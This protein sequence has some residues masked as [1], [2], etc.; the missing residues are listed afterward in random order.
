MKKTF[1]FLFC[2]IGSIFFRSVEA[3]AQLLPPNQPE[4]DAC[5]ALALCGNIFTS[6]YSYQGV[7]TVS[8]L[9]NT[10]CS[11]GEGNSMWLV[12]NVTSPGSIVF[13]LAPSSPEDDYDFAVLDITNTNCGNLSSANVIRCN[14]NNN[15]PGSNVNG[16]IGLNSTSTVTNVTAGATGNSFCQQID[17][18]AGGV[19][20]I[21]INNFGNYQ[22]GGESSGFTIDFT[23]STAT[24]NS[25]GPPAIDSIVTSCDYSQGITLQLTQPIN[26]NSI[27][28]DASDFYLT[29]SGTV[30]S[31]VGNNCNSSGQGY[32]DIINITFSPSLAPGTYTLHPQIGTDGNTLLDLC[33]EPLFEADVISFTIP[34]LPAFESVSLAC[35]TITVQMTTPVDCN[36][37]AA[38]GSN[39]LING[40]ATLN[41]A[42]AAAINCNANNLSNTIVLTLA[43]PI[44]TVGTYTI[45]A[46]AGSGGGMIMDSCGNEQALGDN[47]T[48]TAPSLSPVLSLP[49][50]LTTCVNSGV[51]LPLEIVN[52]VPG[53][54][55]SFN[56]IP[57]NGLSSATAQQPVA[58]PA[59]DQLYTV[60][61]T[62]D[63]PTYCPAFDTVYV[64]VLSGFD[65]LNNDTTV[66]AGAVIQV[67]TVGNNA[68]NYTWSPSDD[69]LNPNDPSTSITANQ[70][71]LY[72]L[73]A[74]YPGCPDSTQYLNI[75]VESSISVELGP[76]QLLCTGDT[77]IIEALISPF[78]NY[79][80]EWTPAG[81]NY[82]PQGEPNI[83]YYGDTSITFH[84]KASTPSGC[85]GTDSVSIQV[86]PKLYTS[87]NTNDTGYCAGTAD[88][89]QLV[90]SGGGTQYHWSP[91]YGLSDST[92]ADPW[93]YPGTTTDYTVYI[94]NDNGCADTQHISVAVYPAAM[95]HLPDSVTLYP[96]EFYQLS[97]ETNCLYFQWFPPS[98][99][100]ADDISNPIAQ[101]EVRTRYF[102]TGTTEHGCVAYDS[103]DVLVEETVVGM[104]NAFV[105]GNG[106]NNVFKPSVKGLAHL[107]AFKIFN[108][109]GEM[110]YQST[111]INEG[112]DGSFNGHPQSVGVYMYLIDGVL[113]NG[114][115]FVM[116]G[117]VTL[118]R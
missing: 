11:G 33:A 9:T 19:Y 67:Y 118:L 42:A 34:P 71:T 23:G 28:S 7:G 50:S 25:D 99:L 31:V 43:N 103:I 85:Y 17:A 89:L 79:T 4:Q 39:F 111:N 96:G 90:I 100:S 73:T 13:T 91:G 45:T 53:I 76:N 64:S 35:S 41:I 65:I 104:P 72:A 101:P 115:P 69:V 54:N 61:V 102:V 106:S 75:N 112:W 86:L 95:I 88:T 114:K 26:C 49:D 68:Y 62:G 83:F 116:Q 56:W 20:L 6:P 80:Y 47:I 82:G 110:V 58:L 59:M 52:P 24:F 87:V 94:Q 29:P 5:N 3:G 40:P 8:D 22:T 77:A 55:Y 1:I 30:S 92:I 15:N 93:V 78:G 70:S 113:D 36:S 14:F 60:T 74:S 57:G 46:Q 44:N 51:T 105:P 98:G 48:F 27:A 109:W 107:N 38:D 84:L 66:C 32:S 108:R 37:I 10:P 117:N 12:L 97:P 2:L 18:V 16:V 81:D 63:D 21:M